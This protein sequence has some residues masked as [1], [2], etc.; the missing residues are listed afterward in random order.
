MMNNGDKHM[1]N[2]KTSLIIFI[3]PPQLEKVKT[4]LAAT[5]SKEFA[6]AFY[7]NC[8]SKLINELAIVPGIDKY[9]IIRKE[10]KNIRV[11]FIP[12]FLM[13][14]RLLVILVQK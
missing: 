9:L 11:N 14:F 8:S 6:L 4:R 12:D 13:Q 7:L 3:R 5:T 10:A 1:V 2:N